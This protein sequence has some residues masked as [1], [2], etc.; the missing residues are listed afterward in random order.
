MR[1]FVALDPRVE[2]N[3]ETV[4]SVVAGMGPFESQAL[5]ILAEHGIE[6]PEAG[7]WY[8]QQAWLDS[9]KAI[10]EQLG[11]EALGRIGRAIPEHAR[12]PPGLWTIHEGLASIDVA[13]HLNHRIEGRVLYDPHSGRLEEGIG[14][15]R[16]ERS[17]PHSAL[18]L[19]H[20]PYPCT[21]DLGII[22]AVVERFHEAG[23][24]PSVQHATGPCRQTGG[25]TCTYLA[26]W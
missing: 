22:Q 23:Q 13:Y 14:H 5:H 26:T 7:H 1:Q 3:G 4:L 12:W 10:A 25:E 19:C 16:Y 15:Y 8:P 2:V 24:A 11:Q 18:L 20:N 6:L 9:F 21:F 17:S